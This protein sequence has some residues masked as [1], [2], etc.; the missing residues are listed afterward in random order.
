MNFL[1]IALLFCLQLVLFFSYGLL[2]FKFIHRVPTS[3]TLTLLS[4]FFILFYVVRYS[5]YPF[6]TDF[7]EIIHSYLFAFKYIRYCIPCLFIFMSGTLERFVT[8]HSF[9]RA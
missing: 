6:D 8:K 2:L 9:I 1:I 4:G 7:T 3:I 5:F